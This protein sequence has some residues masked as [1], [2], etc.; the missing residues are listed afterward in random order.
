VRI[1]ESPVID[2]LIPRSLLRG[3]SLRR[4]NGKER[5]WRVNSILWML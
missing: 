2:V 3:S 1:G 4:P 5:H